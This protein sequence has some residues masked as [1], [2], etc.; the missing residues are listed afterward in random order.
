MKI[1]TKITGAVLFVSAIVLFPFLS[2]AAETQII[3]TSD[4]LEIT[5]WLPEDY[6]DKAEL[7]PLIVFSHGFMT[8]PAQSVF[9]TSALADN[10]YI[11]MAP[12]HADA[13]CGTDG[14]L[15]ASFMN[16]FQ[17]EKTEQSFLSPE[18]WT[19]DTEKDRAQ[20]I[21]ATLDYALKK[22]LLASR[23]DTDNIG[24]MGHSLGGY[25]VLGLAGAVREWSDDRVG[26][27]LAMSP[28]SAPLMM[29]NSL[30]QISIPVMFQAGTSDKLT[31]AWMVRTSYHLTT[32]QKYY[33]EFPTAGHFDWMDVSAKNHANI[34]PYSVAFFDAYLKE[35]SI[36]LCELAD[37][38]N[39]G[40]LQE[41]PVSESISASE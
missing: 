40:F 38:K 32:S 18:N 20:E 15:S 31:Q 9:L 12:R 5:I 35:K 26:A 8:C 17:S 13:T 24:L 29:H 3:T 4:N 2:H 28:F 39:I 30:K 37:R 34:I 41:K 27:V 23:I 21:K 6:K 22:F 25:T 7:Y 10:G 11:V 16:I 14:R 36:E 33:V 1:F 19:S